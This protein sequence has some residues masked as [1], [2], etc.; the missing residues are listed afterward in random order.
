MELQVYNIKG[1]TVGRTV[2]LNDDIFGIEPNNH[3][4]Y[5]DVKRILANRRQGTSKT[6]HRGE[7]A[8][9]TRKIRPQKG[10]G[11]A[12]FGSIK[13]PLFR[14]GGRVFGP[15]P[16]DYSIKINKKVKALARKSALS[17]KA[18]ENAIIIVD[19]VDFDSPK[20]KN[21]VQLKKNFN[22]T[23]KKL[24]LILNEIKNNVIL[25]ARNLKCS[26]ILSVSQLNT[27]DILNANVL[28]MEEEALKS[29]EQI[30][31]T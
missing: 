27:Y 30:L 18:K 21:F 7:I 23:E 11:G 6:K 1:E 26:N 15:V 3:A 31:N 2:K 13:N 14:G 17:S 28:M 9:S 10:T 20:T 24:L 29:L 12:R 5:L 22:I 25:S 19:K 8:G 16:R 4:I